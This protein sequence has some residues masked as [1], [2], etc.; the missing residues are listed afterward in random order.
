MKRKVLHAYLAFVLMLTACLLLK[1]ITAQAAVKKPGK[2][3]I[4]KVSS[5]EPE[6]LAVTWKK[7]SN[8]GKYQVQ[9]ALDKKFTIGRKSKS[10]SAKKQKVTLTKLQG[11]KKYYVRVRAYRIVSGKKY[12][13]K[14][15]AVRSTWTDIVIPDDAVDLDTAP[16]EGTGLDTETKPD[17]STG[18]NTD[19][20]TNTTTQPGRE[21]G[22][23]M[24]KKPDGNTEKKVYLSSEGYTVQINGETSY[25]YTGEEYRPKVT[26][27][28]EGM[29]PLTEGIDYDV[30]YQDNVNAGTATILVEGKGNYAGKLRTTFKITSAAQEFHVNLSSNAICVGETAKLDY[31]GK[32]ELSS[33]VRNIVKIDEDGTITGLKPGYTSI[34]VYAKGDGNHKGYNES[35][36]FLVGNREPRACKFYGSTKDART[37]DGGSTFVRYLRCDAL[38]SYLDDVEYEVTDVTPSAWVNVYADLGVTGTAPTLTAADDREFDKKWEGEQTLTIHAGPGTRAVRVVAKKG[39]NVLDTI[40]M[41]VSCQKSDRSDRYDF[42]EWDVE[43][44]RRV[45]QKVEAKIWTDDMTTH[46]K[47]FAITEYLN[48]VMHYPDTATSSKQYNPSYW[49]KWEIDGTGNLYKGTGPDGLMMCY[50][51]GMGDCWTGVTLLERVAVDDL[52]LSGTDPE[53]DGEGCWITQ[54]AKSSAPDNPLH[55]T[56]RYRDSE[57]KSYSY[58][59]QGMGYYTKSAD[60]MVSCE[61]HDCNSK[62]ISLKD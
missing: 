58:D 49:E 39:G 34:R 47:L 33:L 60:P 26:V 16:E 55:R 19:T 4:V 41:T 48:S 50:M 15:S 11:G 1:C 12:Y 46:Q 8:A 29:A 17:E 27:S 13:G 40:Y 53:G 18:Q 28:K 61:N 7:A 24:E 45:R 10:V 31:T 30:A 38:A 32:V 44:Y 14:W 25:E 2:A 43:M 5:T 57:G 6:K 37:E 22:Q 21:T 9:A 3:E 54:G 23:D 36:P 56:F 62:I 59:V 42:S 35:I 20:N 51:G 52:G